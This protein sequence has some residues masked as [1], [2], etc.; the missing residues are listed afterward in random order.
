MYNLITIKF[1][2]ENLLDLFLQRN[3]TYF[4]NKPRHSV[5]EMS[6]HNEWYCSLSLHCKSSI[7]NNTMSLCNYIAVRDF[8]K[9]VCPIL[10]R[11]HF[12]LF[13]RIKHNACQEP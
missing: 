9:R 7:E 1:F 8:E 4:L 2:Y 11:S 13:D 6:W 10:T 12:Q 3:G 5:L